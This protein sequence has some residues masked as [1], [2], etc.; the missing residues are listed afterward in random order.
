MRRFVFLTLFA[1]LMGLHVPGSAVAEQGAAANGSQS[2]PEANETLAYWWGGGICGHCNAQYQICLRH[3]RFGPVHPTVCTRT[4][5]VQR[6]VCLNS[7]RGSWSPIY[8]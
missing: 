7:C 6:R 1:I 4:C 2:M 5:N 3:C 8:W